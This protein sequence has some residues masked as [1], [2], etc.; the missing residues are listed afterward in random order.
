MSQFVVAWKGQFLH[1][2]LECQELEV[3]L[4]EVSK[5]QRL[6]QTSDKESAFRS[7]A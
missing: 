1:T 2:F 3:G 7:I 5:L 4:H 6:R